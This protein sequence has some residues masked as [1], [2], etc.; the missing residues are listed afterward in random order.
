MNPPQGWGNP[1]LPGEKDEGFPVLVSGLLGLRP[2]PVQ[3][4]DEDR[5][6]EEPHPVGSLGRAVADGGE[7]EQVPDPHPG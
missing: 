4:G 1:S 3:P 7:V 5:E 2:H 6:V